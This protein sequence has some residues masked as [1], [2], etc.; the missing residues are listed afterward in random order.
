[1]IVPTDDD[2]R[3][4]VVLESILNKINEDA[5][6]NGTHDNYEEVYIP[7]E[8]KNGFGFGKTNI[9]NIRMDK[10][11]Y[12]NGKSFYQSSTPIINP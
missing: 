7:L 3:K 5:V 9:I 11:K 8:M 6:A 12:S 4:D 10:M 2:F 1:M